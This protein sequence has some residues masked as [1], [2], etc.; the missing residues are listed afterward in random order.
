MTPETEAA[1]HAHAV[2]EY[3]REC[4]GVIVVRKGRERYIACRNVATTPQDH[5]VL[6]PADFAAAED[7]GEITSIVHSHPDVPARP[8]EGDRVACERS[9]LP[10]VIVSV[11]AGDAGPAPADTQVIEPT[12]YEAPLV[13]RQWAHG[14][15]DCW[16][17]VRDWYARERG[18]ELPDPPRADGWWNDGVSALYNDRVLRDANLV[19]VGADALAPGDVILMQIRSGNQ[20][21]NHAAVYLGDGQIL[22]HLHGR[23]SS[24]DIYGGYWQEVTRSVWR[25]GG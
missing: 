23:L 21:P 1:I 6:S 9:G 25:W 7:E 17:L 5:F 4:C 19:P 24:R 12:G 16:A 11:M 20:V 13:G 15:L 8:S 2:A 22:H 3:P 14:V 10:W 18:V